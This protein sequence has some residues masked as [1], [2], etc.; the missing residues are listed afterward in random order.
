MMS[1]VE[2]YYQ[3][4]RCFRD[5]DL[6][7]DRQPEFTQVDIEL[8]FAHEELIMGVTEGL[9][10]KAFACADI[11]LKP[12]FPRLTYADAMERYGS[13]KPDTRFDLELKDLTEVAGGC[14]LK[15]FRQAAENGGKLKALCINGGAR[16]ISRRELDQYQELANRYGAKGLAWIAFGD[17]GVRSS[18]IDKHLS[19]P[20]IERM[21]EL[22]GARTG[23][24]LLLAADSAKT[25]AN[26]LGRLR[27][28]LGEISG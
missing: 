26:V 19:A 9:L 23:D 5:E 3:I 7:A 13:D 6:R 28:K 27:L 15:V 1:G 18:G 17:D 25:V 24:L 12:P 21:K 10:V 4:A 16:S 14:Q 22:S 20:E 2:R 11:E 8:A